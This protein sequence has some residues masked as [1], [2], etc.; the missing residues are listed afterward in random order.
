MAFKSSRDRS[1]GKENVTYKTSD[2]GQSIGEQSGGSG[3]NQGNDF[4][5]IIVSA[6]GPSADSGRMIDLSNESDNAYRFAS[7]TTVVSFPTSFSSNWEVAGGGGNGGNG[8]GGTPDTQYSNGGRGGQGRPATITTPQATITAG[9]GSGGDGGRGTGS[10]GGAGNPGI[11]GTVTVTYNNPDSTFPG[12]KVVRDGNSGGAGGGRFDAPG[13]DGTTADPVYS[14][15]IGPQTITRGAGGRGGGG[16]PG[17]NGGNGNGGGGGGG[18]G[19]GAYFGVFN[20]KTNTNHNYTITTS[21]D[22]LVRIV[23][24]VDVD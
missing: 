24:N 5:F 4:R 22:S 9:G 19:G 14:G 3:G 8:G 2:I 15:Y 12:I 21:P 10:T 6:P 16:S 20:H 17:A 13:T 1:T 18:G 23:G 7:G 11:A